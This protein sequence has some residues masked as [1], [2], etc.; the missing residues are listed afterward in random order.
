METLANPT[1]S[2]MFRSVNLL[3]ILFFANPP[4]PHILIFY[5][6]PL[7]HIFPKAPPKFIYAYFLA[8]AGITHRIAPR[9]TKGH[10][11]N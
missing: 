7:P 3:H 11:I 10:I 5:P 4:P 1:P 9:N 8:H 2:R 6:P